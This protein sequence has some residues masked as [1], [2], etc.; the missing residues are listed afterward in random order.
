MMKK[1]DVA[2]LVAFLLAAI[3]AILQELKMTNL[4]TVAAAAEKLGVSPFTVRARLKRGELP[5]IRLQTPTGQPPQYAF[6]SDD[7]EIH[8]RQWGFGAKPGPRPRKAVD[9]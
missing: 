5:H 4:M 8:L 2:F 3:T 7:V 1:F 9:V 6:T